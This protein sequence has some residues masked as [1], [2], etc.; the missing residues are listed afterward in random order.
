ME[1]FVNLI[2]GGESKGTELCYIKNIMENNLGLK[3]KKLRKTQS[4][5]LA[6]LSG[7]AGIS[8]SFLSQIENGKQAPTVVTLKKIADALGSPLK[9][10]FNLQ[11][12]TP[13]YI[14]KCDDQ[15][16]GGLQK[17]YK[18]INVLS[19]KFD[20]RIIDCF[21][22]VMEPFF[23]QVEEHAHVGEEFYLVLN[24]ILTVEIEGRE[25]VVNKD[26]SIHFPSS[27]PHRLMNHGEE[28]LRLLGV[29]T[30]TLL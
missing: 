17:I 30:P 6:E 27:Q 1:D 3:I 20:G 22:L 2:E 7:K 15:A 13:E 18:Q 4:L 24:G 16:L 21:N 9:D 28:D 29:F 19:G 14:R 23:E 12:E 11:Q 5:T 26:E 10:L 8:T 25:F